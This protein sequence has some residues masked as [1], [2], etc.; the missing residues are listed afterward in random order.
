MR[1][2]FQAGFNTW[3]GPSAETAD[4]VLKAGGR[5]IIWSNY[6]FYGMKNVTSRP[7][8]RWLQEH[9]AAR[10]R[11][12]EDS[13]TWDK[14]DQYC[15]SYVVGEGRAAFLA[16]VKKSY[17]VMLGRLPG[18]AIIWSDWEEVAWDP[19]HGSPGSGT[20]DAK[21][22]WCF[23]DRCKAEFRKWAKLPAGSS[24]WGPWRVDYS[25]L[26]DW[27]SN[28]VGALFGGSDTHSI[29]VSRSW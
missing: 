1:Q 14:R 11:F 21:G 28:A 4:K 5:L 18:T 15:P 27:N 19:A 9:A 23:C 13:E 20:R 8:Y 3:I 2:S 24:T 29:Q 22:S 10:A 16:E 6:P 17:E 12:F 26:P 25:F 7:G